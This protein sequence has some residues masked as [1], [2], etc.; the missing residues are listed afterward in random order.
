[1]NLVGEDRA[2]LVISSDG[3]LARRPLLLGLVRAHLKQLDLEADEMPIVHGHFEAKD[4]GF[5]AVPGAADVGHAVLDDEGVPGIEAMLGDPPVALD[6]LHLVGQ[7][8]LAAREIRIPVG[9]R[10]VLRIVLQLV[11]VVARARRAGPLQQSLALHPRVAGEG[12]RLALANVDEDEA[13]VF[14]NRVAPDAD[15]MGEGWSFKRLFDTLAG[16]VEYPAVVATAN[17]VLLDEAGG[18][19]GAPVCAT[20]VHH[21]RGSALATIQ[22]EVFVHQPNRYRPAWLELLRDIDGVPERA[23]VAAGQRVRSRVLEIFEIRLG[24]RALSVSGCCCRHL[25]LLLKTAYCRSHV[26]TK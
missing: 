14:L 2:R 11:E 16:A 21:V 6:A 23:Q 13:Q 7:G 17:A 15:A 22:G 12:R 26:W 20:E 8:V 19:L 1:Q 4:L 3:M 18:K 25:C 9:E 24:V 10:H 5:A